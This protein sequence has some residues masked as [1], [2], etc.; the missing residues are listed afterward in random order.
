MFKKIMAPVDL[1]HQDALAKALICT[2]DLANQ[3]D[4][5]VVF[6]GVTASTPSAV[7]H[8]PKEYGEKLA[9]FAAAQAEKYGFRAGSHPVI[10]HDPTAELD[11]ALLRAAGDIGADLVVMASHL[12][13]V[14]D[15]VWPSN[16]GRIAQ[17][18]KCSVFMVRT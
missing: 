16:G 17:H 5:E 15:H 12:P 2:A 13:N 18:A 14:L 9:A 8:N 11:D 6:V 3:Y 1:A 7:A 4:A 10:S